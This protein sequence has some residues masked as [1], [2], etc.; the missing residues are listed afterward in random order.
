MES[1][2]KE[3]LY[4]IEKDNDILFLRNI[5]LSNLFSLPYYMIKH[6]KAFSVFYVV[7]I[8]W[9]TVFPIIICFLL[10]KKIV[11]GVTLSMLDSPAVQPKEFVKGLYYKYKNFQ[12]K[13][14]NYIFVNSTLL[15]NECKQCGYDD[16]I[17]KLINNPVDTTVFHAVDIVKRNDLRRS[18]GID[19]NRFT[20]LFIGSINKRKGADLLPTLFRELHNRIPQGVN[21]IVCGQKGYPESQSI[22][23]ELSQIFQSSLGDFVIKEEV[24]DT[25]PFYQMADLFLFPTTNEGMPNVILEAMASQCMIVCNTLAGITD[26]ILDEVFLVKENNISDY[27]EKIENYVSNP[28][29][30]ENMIIENRKKMEKEFTAEIVDEKIINFLNK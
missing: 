19:V 11:I 14:A 27:I 25:S 21:F 20:I 26:Q 3:N 29:K 15:F 23:D 17:V 7:S 1:S 16:R 8:Y 12:F 18:I 5:L 30:Y 22:I 9:Y 6:R 24:N 10:R 2:Y 28:L 13:L 4:G